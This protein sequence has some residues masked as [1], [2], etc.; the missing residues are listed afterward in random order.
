MV[1]SSIWR[2]DWLRQRGRSHSVSAIYPRKQILKIS[3]SFVSKYLLTASDSYS[4]ACHTKALKNLQQN[5]AALALDQQARFSSLVSSLEHIETVIN[6]QFQQHATRRPELPPLRDIEDV[7]D[8]MAKLALSER[9]MTREQGILRSLSYEHHFDRYQ[10]IA[11][12]HKK[13]FSWV[14]HPANTSS[15]GKRLVQWLQHGQGVF[16]ITGKPGSGK[17][18]MMKFLCDDTRTITALQEWACDKKL[19]IVSHYFWLS[20]TSIQKSQ[21][22]L[23]RSLLQG[24]FQQCPELIQKVCPARWAAVGRDTGTGNRERH[25]TLDELLTAISSISSLSQLAT[26]FCIL[27]DG[28]DEYTGDHVEM[29]NTLQK[30]GTGCPDI[31][32]CVSSRPWN[33]F[34]NAFGG[35]QDLLKMHQLTRDDIC[36]YTR[37][38]LSEHWAWTTIAANTSLADSLIDLI[39]QHAEGVFLWVVLVVKEIRESMSNYDSLEDLFRRV[40]GFPSDLGEFFQQILESVDPFYHAKMSTA[41]QL[42]L[43]A[44]GPLQLHIYY[45][46]EKILTDP[47][48]ALTSPISQPNEEDEEERCDIIEKR[49]TGWCKGLLEVQKHNGLDVQFLHRTV[50]DFLQTPTLAAFLKAK[51]PVDFSANLAI[52]RAYTAWIKSRT[53]FDKPETVRYV[54]ASGDQIREYETPFIWM[55]TRFLS[56]ASRT[57]A[58]QEH[59]SSQIQMEA[60]EHIDEFENSVIKL[61]EGGQMTFQ[62]YEGDDIEE[63]KYAA[64]LFHAQLLGHRLDLYLNHKIT[65]EPGYLKLHDL[66]RYIAA[67]TES[68]RIEWCNDWL[69]N[70]FE[71]V[72]KDGEDPNKETAPGNP[73]SSPFAKLM[74]CAKE[75][76]GGI[77]WGQPV[78]RMRLVSLF[79]DFGADPKASL[80]TTGWNPCRLMIAMPLKAESNAYDGDTYLLELD[81]LFGHGADS[82]VKMQQQGGEIPDTP[83]SAREWFFEELQQPFFNWNINKEV[84]IQVV[85]RLLRRVEDEAEAEAALRGL[86]S[87]W[88]DNMYER[89]KTAMAGS[90]RKREQEWEQVEKKLK[91]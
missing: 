28:L 45:F 43:R 74:Y 49:L 12:A 26:K 16:W 39:L 71:R 2:R 73:S 15:E 37:S 89:T 22:G 14:F 8:L 40:E 32:L 13:T 81:S 17:S 47:S 65:H 7:R 38:R 76:N 66:I 59:T 55:V 18:T 9:D 78:V 33:D 91:R 83:I 23:C 20:G 80:N 19:S 88:P 34:E 79:L 42:T 36:G 62:P 24:I 64:G 87:V 31:K 75:N 27:V 77:C 56:A 57:E 11:P 69:R 41:L 50:R 6:T 29:C 84:V 44:S 54:N 25:W 82:E 72:L 4:H 48:Y 61:E 35:G 52:M 63:N 46:H 60:F 68:Q 21:E 30:L 86:E 85:L 5:A 1:R 51:A 90:K 67:C 53:F 10:S 70:V 58:M 3:K